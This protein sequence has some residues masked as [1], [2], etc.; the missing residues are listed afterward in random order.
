MPRDELMKEARVCRGMVQEFA[1]RP[2]Q[3]F[4]IKLAVI[5]EELALKKQCDNIRR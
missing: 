1:G 2:E 3:P 4:L 5:F